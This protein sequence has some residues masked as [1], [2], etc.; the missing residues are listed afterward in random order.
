[1]IT[2]DLGGVVQL[3]ANST[4]THKR[5]PAETWIKGVGTYGATTDTTIAGL[6]QPIDGGRDGRILEQL[7]EG[8]RTAARYTLHTTDDVRTVDRS[9]GARAD[10]LVYQGK[11]YQAIALANW[12]DQ[13]KFRR[14]VLL[15]VAEG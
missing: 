7:S 12:E 14:L 15:E 9:A 3:F 2:L 11:T 1:M 5:W 6:V 8:Q 4:L 13:G 10:Q